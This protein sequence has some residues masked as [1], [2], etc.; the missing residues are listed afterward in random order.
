MI[1]GMVILW[2]AFFLMLLLL[3]TMAVLGMALNEEL[4]LD[5]RPWWGPPESGYDSTCSGH[6]YEKRNNS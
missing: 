2:S 5:R 1:R 3:A 4:C 6:I